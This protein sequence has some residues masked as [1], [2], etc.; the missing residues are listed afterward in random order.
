MKK[1]IVNFW[2]IM[3]LIAS[4]FTA[5]VNGITEQSFLSGLGSF[6]GMIFM[7]ACAVFLAWGISQCNN[8][9]KWLF[10]GLAWFCICGIICNTWSYGIAVLLGISQ[11]L[12]DW[13]IW[14]AIGPAMLAIMANLVVVCIPTLR[15][16]YD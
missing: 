13:L 10:K 4:I 12:P 5:I 2:T 14:L 9:V 3:G 1:F 8:P 15:K 11:V 6:G 7:L 16:Q